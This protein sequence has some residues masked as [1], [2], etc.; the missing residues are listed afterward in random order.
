M[1]WRNLRMK[2]TAPTARLNW[3]D[4]ELVEAGKLETEGRVIVVVE[5]VEVD[6]EGGNVVQRRV[7]LDR[8]TMLFRSIVVLRC[9]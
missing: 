9:H 6:S 4:E 7:V 2:M 1:K 8:M 3:L 5:E